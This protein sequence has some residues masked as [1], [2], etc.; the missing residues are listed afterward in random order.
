[1]KD[2]KSEG[3]SGSH[4]MGGDH[5]AM[6]VADFRKRFWISLALTI[7]I[8]LLDPMFQSLVGLEGVIKFPGD[9]WFL[10][11]FSTAIYIYGGRP[12]LKGLADEIRKKL[13]GMMTLIG[14]AIS[15]AFFYS[16][17]IVLGLEGKVFFWELATLIDVMLLGHWIEMR[18]VMGASKAL[19]E[20]VKLIPSEAHRVNED[21]STEDV[22]VDD[23]KKGD[24]YIVRPG[25][26]F[27]I[28]GSIIEGST[29][30][31]ES[32]LTGES[33]PVKKKEGDGVVGGALNGS[34]SVTV[35][36][37]KTGGD[38]F[39]SQVVNMVRSAQES[40]SRT[41][42][43][44]NRAAFWLTII[45][46][47]SGL[48]TLAVWLS[49]K[50]DFTYSLER[51][52]T[53]MVI[54]CPH[55]LGL[56][57][58]LVVAVSTGIGASKGL[59]IRNRASFEQARTIDAVVFDKTGTLTKGEFGVQKI[60]P[61]SDRDENEILR[62]AATVESDSEH[63]LAQ[64][65]MREAEKRDIKP[66]KV[67]DFEAV[68]GK[69][70]RG[71]VD[72]KS[73]MI[74]SPVYLQENSIEF[75]ENKISGEWDEGRTVVFVL[76]EGN[77]I[78]AISLGDRI[79]DES[80][81]A[82]KNLKA[83]DIKCLMV[84]GDNR[85]VAEAVSKKLGLDEF[86]AEVLPDKK[87]EKIRE[88]QGK[89]MRVAM[90]GDGINDAPALATADLG[91]AIGAG[92]DVAV[93]TADVVLVRS[94]PRDVVSIF[95]LANAT[96]KKMVQNLFY[97][98]GYNVVAIPLAAGVLAGVGIILSPAVG[99]VLMSISTVVVAINARFMSID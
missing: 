50:G 66:G 33:Q 31:D 46:I 9:K 49:I 45:A 68:K 5:H 12:F 55:A 20:L 17:A 16:A 67:T 74:S 98:T 38:T 57:V 11:A 78:G 29:T 7:P 75:D 81:E 39:I 3:H 82:I 18:F 24:R 95:R 6:M 56:A 36:V 54:T 28:D 8:L 40:K 22:A 47:S 99:A 59:L 32:M 76:E 77:L 72:G 73:V 88:I 58:P 34:G 84:T 87:A 53:V 26:K 83:M 23:L 27:P 64:G 19:E 14:L 62:L 63:P 1:L 30:V 65:I 41:Q 42:D 10:L 21:G 2:H 92:T 37:E 71:N 60:I 97:A 69:G 13:P 43:I 4:K 79:R 86:Y 61:L 52:V 85:R 35:K 25:E 80:V 91:I 48:I 90:T 89:K 96:Y 94:D 15:V 51:M 44:A 93:E 70:A